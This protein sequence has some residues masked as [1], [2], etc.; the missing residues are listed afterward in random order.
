MKLYLV[1]ERESSSWEDCVWAS[2]V[3]IGNVLVGENRY[4][5]TR[6]EYEGLRFAATGVR[7]AEG[8]GSNY[9]ELE[10]GIRVR[11][12]I[13]PIRRGFGFGAFLDAVPVGDYGAVQGLYA[14]MPSRLRITSFGGGHSFVVHRVAD[15][16]FDLYDPLA[17]N[18][19]EPRRI[20]VDELRRYYDAL[21]GAAWIAAYEGEA[22][23]APMIRLNFERWR[24]RGDRTP[25]PVFEN[26]N[27]LRPVS[28]ITK[29]VTLT[30]IGIP[31]SRADAD[32]VDYDWRAVI[33]S[34]A[35]IDKVTGR[36][37]AFIRRPPGDPVP[38][39]AAWDAALYTALSDPA[40]RGDEVIDATDAQIT[41]ARK[42]GA[43]SALTSADVAIEKLKGAVTG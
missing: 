28:T 25:V 18:G 30:S 38:T 40:F 33:V 16:Q 11:Y 34:S 29:D 1:S 6:T 4:P 22:W 17:V 8:D 36:K 21:P 10:R 5:A 20:T 43:L 41:A 2:G 15:T 39:D 27:G 32:G 26:P 3:M 7:E 37:I 42:E 19:S 14:A 24:V 13:T 23:R 12:D 35:A 9:T 31:L